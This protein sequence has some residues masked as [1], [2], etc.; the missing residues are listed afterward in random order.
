MKFKIFITLLASLFLVSCGGKKDDS[1]MASTS[2][3]SVI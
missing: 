1:N 3:P 2:D